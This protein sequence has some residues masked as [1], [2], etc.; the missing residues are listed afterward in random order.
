[1]TRVLGVYSNKEL[2][3]NCVKKVAL[4][5]FS[6]APCSCKTIV[7]TLISSAGG[8]FEKVHQQYLQISNKELVDTQARGKWG[9]DLRKKN[10]GNHQ[11]GS[12]GY[13]EKNTI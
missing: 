10:L 3:T 4:G 7:M 13:L 6:K 5:K 1:M 8:G 11:L 9:K 12:W 2:K